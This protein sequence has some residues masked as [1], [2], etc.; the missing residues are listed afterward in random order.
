MGNF[1]TFFQFE[2]GW[3][4]LWERLVAQSQVSVR[5]QTTV[6]DVYEGTIVTAQ[7][8]E[9]FDLVIVTTPLDVSSVFI[10][11]IF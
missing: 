8:Q 7:G 10:T 5:L 1:P 11:M 6:T 9:N 4:T 2:E 3:Q